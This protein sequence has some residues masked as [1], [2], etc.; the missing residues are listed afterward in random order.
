[1]PDHRLARDISLCDCDWCT[2]EHRRGVAGG[3]WEDDDDDSSEQDASVCNVSVST[4]SNNCAVD[5][6]DDRSTTLTSSSLIF[7]QTDCTCK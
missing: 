5:V 4:S 6:L 7:F 2:V 3:G 1:M